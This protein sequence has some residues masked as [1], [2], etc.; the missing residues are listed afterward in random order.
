MNFKGYLTNNGYLIENVLIA[1]QLYLIIYRLFV[2]AFGMT[3]EQRQ[4]RE[5][6]VY[7]FEKFMKLVIKDTAFKKIVLKI[8]KS[9]IL[10]NIAKAI[11][12]TS[13]AAMGGTKAL[14]L[15]NKALDSEDLDYI[16][17]TVFNKRAIICLIII[18]T[19]LRN[20][21]HVQKS[22]LCLTINLKN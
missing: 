22:I 10:V 18:S 2:F 21:I 14:E 20:Y 12:I 15:L 1:P 8:V 3:K 13:N 9:K 17:D 4:L 5:S 19:S 16:K 7:G 11:E 6:V